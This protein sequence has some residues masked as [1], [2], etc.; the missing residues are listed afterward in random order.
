MSNLFSVRLSG[1][2]AARAARVAR[3]AVPCESL[4]E[5]TPS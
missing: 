3:P 2:S 5:D 4:F 1:A